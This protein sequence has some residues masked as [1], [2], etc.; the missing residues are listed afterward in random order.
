MVN[1][2]CMK[3]GSKYGP[4]YV[5][6]LRKMVRRNLSLDHRFV[7]FTDDAL[8]LD[9]DIEVLPLPVCRLPHRPETEAWRKISLFGENIGIKGTS[10]FLDLD[11]V[12][13]GSLDPFFSHEGRFCIIHNWTHPDRRVGN[14]SVFRFEAGHHAGIF[15]EFENDPDAVTRSFRNEQ[16]FVSARID[17]SAGLTWWPENWCKSFKKHCL[18]R[19]I[20]QVF[21]PSLPTENCRIVVFHGSPNPPEAAKQWLYGQHKPFRPR[22]L[23]RPARWILDYWK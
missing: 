20:G 10:L 16:I 12:V 5:N 9:A 4:E 15:H 8:G 22:K 21:Y 1:V 19:G 14:S 23:M 11:I 13:V 18:P 7:C 3:W 2:V 17:T 6:I